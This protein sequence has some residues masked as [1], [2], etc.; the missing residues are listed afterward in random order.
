MK[1]NFVKSTG[2]LRAKSLLILFSLLLSSFMALATQ[3]TFSNTGAID[4]IP[5]NVDAT[6][7]YNSGTWAIETSMPYQTQHTLNY[8]NTGNGTTSGSMIGSVGWEFDYGPL[9]SGGR[10]MSASFYN[11][12]SAIIQAE[13]GSIPNPPNS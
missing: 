5:P 3:S 10:G 8:T 7:F 6:N 2:R 13:D 1:F 4:G 12:S 9:P 11:D